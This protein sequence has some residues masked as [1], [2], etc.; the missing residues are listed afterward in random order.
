M[1]LFF[2]GL[3]TA[4]ITPFVNN[5]L[6]EKSFINLLQ[7]QTNTDGIVIGGTTG[8]SPTITFEELIQMINVAKVNYSGK[9]LVGA[10][11]NNTDECIK[12]IKLLDEIDN[13]DGYL[14][15]A[16]YYN[17]PNQRGIFEHFAKIAA[18]T[19]RSII[20][21]SIPGRCG[22]EIGVETVVELAE[23]YPNIVGIKEATDNCSRIDDMTRMLPENFS[24]LSGN[25]NITLPFM[26]LGAHGVI[27]ASSNVIVKEMKLLVDMCLNGNFVPARKVHSENI[28]KMRALFR[29]PNPIA[30]KYILYKLGI[31]ASPETRLPLYPSSDE[32][33]NFIESFF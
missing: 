32:N 29:E 1:A 27:S 14:I 33:L 4:V 15:V 13:I 16:P 24:I 2:S 21:Y 18:N 7:T 26:S 23:K 20:L 17:K 11:G 12:K 10:G 6:D 22:V 25:D 9:I 28:L 8:E 31:I 30:I 5:K 3:F 19:K